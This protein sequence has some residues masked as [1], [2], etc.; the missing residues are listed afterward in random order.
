M[1]VVTQ[2]TGLTSHAIRAWERRYGVVDPGRSA[3]GHRLY[4]DREVERLRL[5]HRLT[6]GGRQI[7][8]LSDLSDDELAALLSEDESAGMTAPG[9]DRPAA[10]DETIRLLDDAMDAVRALDADTLDAILRRAALGLDTIAYLEHLMTPL[11]RRIGDAWVN[12]EVTPAHEHLASAVV[13][14]VGGWLLDNLEPD[15][16]APALVLATPTGDRH[17]LGAMAAAIAAASAGWKVLYLGSDL[18]AS[19]IAGAALA[20]G[21]KAVALSLVFGDAGDSV[22]AELLSLRRLLP[23]SVPIIAGGAAAGMYSDEI[24]AIGGVTL[25]TFEQLRLRLAREYA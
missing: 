17:E 18:P 16:D 10:A 23:A 13:R 7:G 6:I 25:E 11:L 24:E 20:S 2:R 1:G 9:V 15:G 4:S 8:Q 21:A 22:G 12:E 5:L 19:D 3:G 14:R